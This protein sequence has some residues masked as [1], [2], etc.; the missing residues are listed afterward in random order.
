MRLVYVPEP[1]PSLDLELAVVGFCVVLQQTPL[2]VMA[3][4]PSDVIFPPDAAVVVVIELIVEVVKV[5]TL[6][7]VVNETSFP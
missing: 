5:G 7:K 1:L 3:P 6:A 2:A 4:P